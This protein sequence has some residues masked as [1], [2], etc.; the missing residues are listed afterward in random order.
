MI[1]TKVRGQQAANDCAMINGVPGSKL[2]EADRIRAEVEQF[3]GAG[4]S[5]DCVGPTE[6]ADTQKHGVGGTPSEQ[7]KVTHARRE[8]KRIEIKAKIA[9]VVK[10]NPGLSKKAIWEATKECS[11][12]TTLKIIDEM[13][14]AGTLVVGETSGPRSQIYPGDHNVAA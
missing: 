6:H 11:Y 13:L 9:T 12:Q 8:Q 3:L 7:R 5:I 4:G 1:P 14:S 2:N 10:R